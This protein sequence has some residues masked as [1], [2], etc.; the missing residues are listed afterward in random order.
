MRPRKRTDTYPITFQLMSNGVPITD[1]AGST[2]TLTL[3]NKATGAVKISNAACTITDAPT[4]A[5][6]YAP[7][8]ADVDTTGAYNLEIKQIR[9]DGTI[10]HFPSSSYEPLY[11]EASLI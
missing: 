4:A 1:A 5:C 6:S 3:V 7:I 9:P 8:A 10:R 11:I 2:I